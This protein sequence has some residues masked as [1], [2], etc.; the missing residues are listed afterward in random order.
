MLELLT[1][2]KMSQNPSQESRCQACYLSGSLLLSRLLLVI[3]SGRFLPNTAGFS[4]ISSISTI[5]AALQ[6]S[7]ECQ[8]DDYTVFL[9]NYHSGPIPQ[10]Q[11]LPCPSQQQAGQKRQHL[12]VNSMSRA[13]RPCRS[14]TVGEYSQGKICSRSRC[15][16]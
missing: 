2:K 1:S 12:E 16:G 13:K 9:G 14:S 11:T 4:N 3:F 7:L 5:C 15:E 8:Q 10:P 6:Y